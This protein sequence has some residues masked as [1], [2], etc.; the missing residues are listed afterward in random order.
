[1]KVYRATAAETDRAHIIDHISQDSPLA[2]IQMD[3]LFADAAARLANHPRLGKAGLIPGTRE[4]IPH[5]SYWL[6]YEVQGEKVW[7]LALVNTARMWP[8]RKP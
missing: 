7:I 3:E 2:A 5:E 1:M 4:L 8:A 6:V